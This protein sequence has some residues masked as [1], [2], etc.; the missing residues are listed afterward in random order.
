MDMDVIRV[1]AR[2]GEPVAS[3]QEWV[4]CA[5]GPALGPSRQHRGRWPLL[6][7]CGT[8]PINVSGLFCELWVI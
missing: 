7:G 5:Q 3:S 8:Y 6:A 1:M 4:S 2:A